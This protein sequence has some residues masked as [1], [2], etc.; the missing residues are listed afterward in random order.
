MN[1]KT[2]EIQ[3]WL[4]KSQEDLAVAQL[5]I[6]QEREYL[7]IAV[8]HCQ[9]SLEKGLKGYL[10]Y[11]DVPFQKTHDLTILNR[12]CMEFDA[13]FRTLIDASAIL[14]PYATRFRYPSEES[15]PDDAE[16]HAAL[17]LTSEALT[18]I[19]QVLSEALLMEES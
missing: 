10:T 15:E 1:E 6:N 5:L 3:L 8:Y 13:R 12:S 2:Q 9:Q 16:A 7:S 17:K 4:H 14:T 11:Q 19:Q 18:L